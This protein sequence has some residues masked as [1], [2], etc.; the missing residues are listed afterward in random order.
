M[1]DGFLVRSWCR[2]RP[3]VLSVYLAALSRLLRAESLQFVD[4][5][6]DAGYAAYRT[7]ARVRVPVESLLPVHVGRGPVS[8]LSSPHFSFVKAHL[9]RV[10]ARWNKNSWERYMTHESA[11][12]VAAVAQRQERFERLIEEIRDDS[13]N[14]HLLVAINPS[15]RGFEIVDGF[16]RAAIVAARQPGARVSCSVVSHIVA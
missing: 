14:V 4:E 9:G 8:I 16:H 15:L 7:L 11:S 5:A 12:N 2:V 3:P 10:G 1:T 13:A 6:I